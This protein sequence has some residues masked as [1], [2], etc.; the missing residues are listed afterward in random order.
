MRCPFCAEHETRVLDSRL[1]HEGDQV[2]RRRECV[3]CKARFTTYEVA[4][5][6]LP[7]VVKNNGTREPFDDGKLR[8]GFIKALEKRPV[9][10]ESVEQAISRIK[11]SLIG[12]SDSEVA[13]QFLGEKVM[14]E[15]RNLDHVAYVRFSSVYRSFEDVSE[16]NDVIANLHDAN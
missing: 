2:R 6:Q 15:L 3:V 11:R 8:S 10:R 7:D 12:K 16:F 13:S 9:N 4:E 1:A 5:L 14:N